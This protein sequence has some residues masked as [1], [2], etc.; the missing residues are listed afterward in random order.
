[1]FHQ[2]TPLNIFCL[3]WTCWSCLRICLCI[4]ILFSFNL[5]YQVCIWVYA[6]KTWTQIKASASKALN[7]FISGLYHEDLWIPRAKVHSLVKAGD[8]FLKAYSFLAWKAHERGEPKFS[9]KPKLHMFHESVVFL[10]RSLTLNFCY[11]IIAES[12]SIDEDMVGR[13]AFL[14]RNVS[15][16]LMAL[17]SL[18]RYLTQIHL[19]WTEWDCCF[20]VTPTL[21][22]NGAL[23]ILYI[24]IYV[25]I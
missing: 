7:Y 25:Y 22:C 4:H 23:W 17:R 3:D 5:I 20:L 12:C 14:S 24:Y 6:H 18:Q 11:N 16:R 15:P 19:A 21:V 8:H 10:R 13:L 1:M 2:W 9:Y